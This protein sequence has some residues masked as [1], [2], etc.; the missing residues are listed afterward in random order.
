MNAG[1]KWPPQQYRPGQHPTQPRGQNVAQPKAAAPQVRP[2]PAAP[3]A[4]RPQPAPK[5][6]QTKT[7]TVQ[8]PADAKGRAPAAP[9]VYRPQPV[10]KVLQR[11]TVGS[12]P[13]H[14][15]RPAHNPAAP[16]AYHPQPPP[17]VLQP[18]SAPERKPPVVATPRTP[19]APP[20]YVPG[21]K[22][23]LQ[24]KTVCVPPGQQKAQASAPA[25]PRP[26]SASRGAV[27]QP[28]IVKGKTHRSKAYV[29]LKTT[30]WFNGLPSDIHRAFAQALHAEKQKYTTGEADDEIQ[31]RIKRGDPTP[32]F[33]VSDKEERRKRVLEYVNTTAPTIPDTSHEQGTILA[34]ASGR[35]Y[36]RHVKKY[37][38]KK[39]F[40][41]TVKTLD[42]VKPGLFEEQEKLLRDQNEWQ[43]MVALTHSK[44]QTY[45]F[46]IRG[47]KVTVDSL[48][49]KDNETRSKKRKRESI[50]LGQLF[51]EQT[52]GVNS[53]QGMSDSTDTSLGKE[54]PHLLLRHLEVEREKKS[55]ATTYL[56]DTLYDFGAMTNKQ[57]FGD[58]VPYTFQEYKGA[59]K[60]TSNMRRIQM[61][62]AYEV[63]QIALKDAKRELG[64]PVGS[65]PLTTPRA[66]QK[67]LD[68]FMSD[69]T[70]VKYKRLVKEIFRLIR[71]RTRVEIESD[72][73]PD[74]DATY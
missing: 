56:K 52:G 14:D 12:Q 57:A 19:T 23:V 62:S 3:P 49:V 46:D 18:K 6:L 68:A 70:E 21:V 16:P 39:V 36:N 33:D 69:K 9:P 71:A 67:A 65:L 60:P 29:I 47:T 38:R 26:D 24:P 4:Y 32:T 43:Q 74:S 45:N 66:I 28:I 5:V 22:K 53:Y 17:K 51:V 72:S 34:E 30:G 48:D 13:P 1:K 59:L 58:E 31:E 25:R 41:D 73:E 50:N 10:P 11:K 54:R 7:A 63:L 42:E 20:A 8:G 55:A 64:K 15:A 44:P 61:T 37:K 40:H 35:A 2:A 27:I